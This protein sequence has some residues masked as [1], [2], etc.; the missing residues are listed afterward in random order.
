MGV[1]LETSHNGIFFTVTSNIIYKGI[2]QKT[3]NKAEALWI[4]GTS[5]V[6]RQHHFSSMY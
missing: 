4:D 1:K 3:W 6:L 5:S 2:V